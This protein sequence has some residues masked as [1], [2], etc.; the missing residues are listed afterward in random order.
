MCDGTLMGGNLRSRVQMTPKHCTVRR[1]GNSNLLLLDPI[2]KHLG[3]V[4]NTEAPNIG[5]GRSKS[6]LFQETSNF[7][8]LVAKQ[9]GSIK[10]RQLVES[11]GWERRKIHHTRRTT[12]ATP[13]KCGKLST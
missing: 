8:N 7:V 4:R 10:G 6:G 5:S 13:A 11:T 9:F 1:N 12:V 3:E 2:G